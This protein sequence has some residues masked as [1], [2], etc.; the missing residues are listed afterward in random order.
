MQMWHT[1]TDRQTDS[2]TVW[3]VDSG[4]SAYHRD[5]KSQYQWTDV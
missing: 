5:T 3:S 4:V 2:R 1:Q